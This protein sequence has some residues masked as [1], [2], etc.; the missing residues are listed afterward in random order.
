MNK[1][2]KNNLKGNININNDKD[3]VK[4]NTNINIES[5]INTESNMFV[6]KKKQDDKK[7]KKVFNVYMM[8]EKLKELDKACKK[9]GYSRNEMV[10][11]MIEHCLNNMK[12]ED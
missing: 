11:I 5:N 8:P 3:K 10:N 12:L 6:L 2:F 4:D 1:N 7:D 9:S